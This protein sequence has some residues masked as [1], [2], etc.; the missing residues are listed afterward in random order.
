MKERML[1]VLLDSRE[2]MKKNRYI[3][4][5]SNTY[6]LEAGDI[7][8]LPDYMEDDIDL[9]AL[10]DDIVILI[11]KNKPDSLLKGRKALESIN[12]KTLIDTR[13]AFI[14]SIPK[15]FIFPNFIRAY[16]ERFIYRGSNVYHI[17]PQTIRDLRLER[18]IRNR[19]NAYCL[20]QYK[21]D[22]NECDKKYEDLYNQIKTNGYDDS[23][24]I[25]VMLCRKG[26][27]VDSLKQGHHRM[28][29]CLEC[30]IPLITVKFLAAGY[31]PS[32]ISRFFKNWRGKAIK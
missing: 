29:V 15:W 11:Q 12:P 1:S 16:R 2:S 30:G 7:T 26:G 31:M 32:F 17:Q 3:G 23:N 9:S 10:T 6:L 22:K 21:F 4:F 25:F 28:S 24:P 19:S 8:K 20:R 27:M 18:V 14:P 13:V 5:S